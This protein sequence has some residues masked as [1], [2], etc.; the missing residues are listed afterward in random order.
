[1]QDLFVF[2]RVGESSFRIS[3]IVFC[4]GLLV[5]LYLIFFLLCK[6]L[7]KTNSALFL[8]CF[9]STTVCVISTVMHNYHGQKYVEQNYA[10]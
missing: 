4:F 9:K 6:F 10:F 8:H 2:E 5:Y 7:K 1:M 3:S